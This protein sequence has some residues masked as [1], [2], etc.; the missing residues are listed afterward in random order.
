MAKS[1]ALDPALTSQLQRRQ[2]QESCERRI[3]RSCLSRYRFN[4]VL[5]HLGDLLD[6]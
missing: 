4:R 5:Q 1:E 3:A 2:D 6:R